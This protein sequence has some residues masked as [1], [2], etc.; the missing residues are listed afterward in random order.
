MKGATE[1]PTTI[2]VIIIQYTLIKRMK[3]ELAFP[4]SPTYSLNVEYSSL[5][6]PPWKHTELLV[7]LVQLQQECWRSRGRGICH[8]CRLNERVWE[9]SGADQTL[10]ILFAQ[11]I[12]CVLA[13]PGPPP[14]LLTACSR[15]GLA[16]VCTDLAVQP[17]HFDSSH[18]QAKHAPQT[19]NRIPSVFK[20][21]QPWCVN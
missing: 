12:R 19:W 15:A 16:A 18:K 14:S 5:G 17:C 6:F 8:H 21:K 13:M 11:S 1:V 7:F 10:P 20:E 9:P 3:C 4:I 2:T